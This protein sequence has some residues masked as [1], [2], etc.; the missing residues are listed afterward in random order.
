MRKNWIIKP[1]DKAAENAIAA[2]AGLSRVTAAVLAARGFTDAESARGFISPVPAAEPDPFLMTDMSK[3]VGRI[4]AAMENGETIGIIGDY[5]VDGITATATLYKYFTGAGVKSVYH[6]PSRDGEGYGVSKDTLLMLKQKGCSLVITVDC[7]ITAVDE[8][9]YCK[10][11]GLDMIVTDHHEVGDVIPDA[12]AVINPKRPGDAYPNSKL[13]GVG[14]A[15]KLALALGIDDHLEEYT[16]FAALGTLADMMPVTG[17]NRTIII[18]GM[19][20]IQSGVNVG[21]TELMNKAG[22]SASRFNSFSVSFILAPRMN[23][24]GRI[25]SAETALKLLLEDDSYA[26]GL[27]AEKLCALNKTRQE[28]E[29]EIFRQAVET[30]ESDPGYLNDNIIVLYNEN[31]HQGVIG[32]VAAKITEKYE[33]PAILF[34]LA[35]GTGKGSGRSVSGFSIHKAVS[36]CS[37]LLTNFG[38]HEYAVGLGIEIDKIP[39][40]RKKINEAT[41]HIEIL[42]RKL[43]IDAEIYP[44][45]L[46][47]DTVKSI[48]VLEPYGEGNP[49]PV[50]VLRGARISHMKIVGERHTRVSLRCGKYG[51]DAIYYNALPDGLDVATGDDADVAFSLGI[52]EYNGQE[53]LQIVIKDVSHAGSFEE[54]MARFE[55]VK[56]SG[57]LDDESDM[58]RFSDFERVYRALLRLNSDR[59]RP[60]AFAAELSVSGEPIS[61]LK[62]LIILSVFSELSLVN[63]VRDGASL[64][65]A[66]VK[67]APKTDLDNSVLLRRLKHND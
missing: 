15:Y 4:R 11:I 54:D 29:A 13:S 64:A 52:N 21:L 42:P 5:D 63:V 55:Q 49:Q 1:Y 14:V 33:K 26:A 9:E 47:T 24:A 28:T 43:E 30:V 17:E 10:L 53:N 36:A 6:I 44:D 51:Y 40:F 3:A 27:I 8:A 25:E 50:F 38:G 12:V 31:W 32:I 48:N 66:V 22:V 46:S 2:G 56:Q 57:S 34:T 60:D 20:Y 19:N 67:D 7:G 39:E 23:A 16:A 65:V 61:A 59:I 18:K 41:S 62:L 37:D 35:N 58:P 45:E